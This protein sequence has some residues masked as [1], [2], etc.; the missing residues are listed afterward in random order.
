M[1]KMDKPETYFLLAVIL[2]ALAIR[3]VF[4]VGFGLGDDA[5]YAYTSKN[6]M[7]NGQGEHNIFFWVMAGIRKTEIV[8]QYLVYQIEIHRVAFGK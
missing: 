8:F 1:P 2:L 4:F 3:I 7:E 5:Y 6:F